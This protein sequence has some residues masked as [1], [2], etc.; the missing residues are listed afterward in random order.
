LDELNRYLQVISLIGIFS[1]RCLYILGGWRVVV[2]RCKLDICIE[3]TASNTILSIHRFRFEEDNK[4]SGYSDF[5]SS[6]T[7]WYSVL[8]ISFIEF[9]IVFLGVIHLASNISSSGLKGI[10][11]DEYESM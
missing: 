3:K 7:S 4:V 2:T 1:R 9:C 10:P 5:I 11:Y 6:G 8:K